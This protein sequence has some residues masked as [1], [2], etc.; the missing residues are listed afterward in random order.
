VSLIYLSLGSNIGDRSENIVQ[1]ID[2][3]QKNGV[4]VTSQS[5]LYET[6]PADVPEDLKSQN[7]F[8]NCVVEAETD[9]QPRE[10]MDLLLAIERGLGRERRVPK[11]PR[12]IDIDILLFDS[13]V[14]H[15]PGVEIPHPRMAERRFVLAPFAEIAP[16]ARHPISGKTIVELLA[17]VPDESEVR[18]SS[19]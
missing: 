10:L 12:T 15:E 19:G 17:I 4:R 3:L 16:Q 9:L 13:Q 11:G 5:S 7:W 2:A 14:I 8:V 6:E 18:R 1:A